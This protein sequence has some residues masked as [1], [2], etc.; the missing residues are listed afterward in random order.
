MAY[1]TEIFQEKPQEQLDYDVQKISAGIC[2][3]YIYYNLVLILHGLCS[4]G[5]SYTVLKVPGLCAT[6]LRT[7]AE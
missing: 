5:L 4:E 2:P 6:T 1:N 7:S 3:S